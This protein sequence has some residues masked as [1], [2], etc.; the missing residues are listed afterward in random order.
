LK[1][2]EQDAAFYNEMWKTIEGGEVWRGQFH[3]KKKNGELF[4]EAA[5]ISAIYNESGTLI[6]FI[7]VGE[8]ITQQK[9]T[10]IELK[11]ALE[12]AL[13]SERLKSAFL[14]N[15][16]HEIRTPM[17]GILGFINLLNEPDLNKDQIDTYSK[18]INKS[19]NRLLNTINDII[20]IS[21]IEAGEVVISKAE[22]AINT[23]MEE[24]YSFFLPEANKKGLSLLI[25]PSLLTEQVML[26]TDS[27]KF[28]GILTNLIKNAIKFTDK[29][30]ISFGYFQK[31]NFIEFFVKDTGI[32]IPK[33]RLQAIFNRFEQADI[34][35][36]RV[37]E[38]SGLGLAISKAYIQ[39]LGGEIFMESEEGKGSKFTFT[40][41]FT[42][43]QK[44][45]IIKTSETIDN[46]SSKFGD[47]NLLIAE[48][49]DLSS[50]LLEIMLE[51]IFQKIIIARTGIEAVQLCKNNS[52]VNL[53]LMDIKMP[54]MNGYDATREIRKFNK[55][56]VIIAQTAY[57]MPGDKEKAIEVGCNDYISKPI[58]KK[59]LLEIISKHIEK[60]TELKT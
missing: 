58:N 45:G 22:I 3:N 20:D 40:L 19:G 42:K 33:D 46:T 55:D 7:K 28:H 27:H 54:E 23:E 15:M 39:M 14:A 57:A 25:E 56:L 6:N 47:L 9:S 24:L 30:S 43:N 32:G 50:E 38:G 26:L 37:F 52:E 4:W 11:A 29:G 21:K 53:V 1:S 10:E 2:G 12:K 44:E 31:E 18:I 8:D 49:D 41:P 59:L 34:E 5:S 35:D 16:S 51:G 13:E 48:D 60:R 17:N 36:T